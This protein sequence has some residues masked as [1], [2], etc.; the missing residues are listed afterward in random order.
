MTGRHGPAGMGRTVAVVAA[1]L[2]AVLALGACSTGGGDDQGQAAQG[3]TSTSPPTT[4]APSTAAP[5]TK[6][7]PTTAAPTTTAPPPSS[8]AEMPRDRI[9]VLATGTVQE[10]VEPGCLI[11]DTGKGQRYVLLSKDTSKL[12]PGAKVAVVG[13]R[14]TGQVSYCQQGQ[15]LEVQSVR[16]AP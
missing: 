6:P 4:A 12:K 16:P 8:T 7:A 2:A 1:G 3:V 10:G 5:T 15:P 14:A 13:V 9:K 11:L